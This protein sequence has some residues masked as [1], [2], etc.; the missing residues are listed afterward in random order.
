MSKKAI[1]L[2]SICLFLFPFV[3]Q[4][5]RHGWDSFFELDANIAMLTEIISLTILGVIFGRLYCGT[6]CQIGAMQRLFS[7]IGI[8]LFKKRF[9]IPKTAD[10]YM[11]CLK[12]VFLAVIVIVSV[13]HMRILY[14]PYVPVDQFSY[15]LP[16]LE[17]IS[18]LILVSTI[19]GGILFNNFFCKYL[20]IQGAIN[21]IAGS[22]SSLRIER[23]AETCIG[24][25]KC[26]KKCPANLDVHNLDIIKSK[27]CLYCQSCV[28]ACPKK[29]ALGFYFF[30]KKIPYF[31]V[32][33]L[34]VIV[35]IALVVSISSLLGFLL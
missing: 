5:G 16:D 22:F 8:K 32:L 11:R 12:Y 21:G 2:L 6:L 31:I 7:W 3:F 10:R 35:Y 24:C 1:I 14:D 27:E 13:Y 29:D 23:N 25:R 28:L 34:V 9:E 4:I 26:T 18:A 33:I 20:C 15:I 19:A 30:N 17:I